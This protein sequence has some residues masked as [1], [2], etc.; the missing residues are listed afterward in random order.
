MEVSEVWSHWMTGSDHRVQGRLGRTQTV[1]R[2]VWVARSL[3]RGYED[4]DDDI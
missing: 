3:P 2:L 4:A 1:A